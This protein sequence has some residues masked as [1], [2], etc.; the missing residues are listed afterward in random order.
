MA[1]EEILAGPLEVH[2][3]PRGESF[4]EP[5]ASPNGE[6][7]LLGASGDE[8]YTDDGVAVNLPQSIEEFIG[9]GS[10]MAIK[11]WR[12]EEAVEIVVTV[13]DMSLEVLGHALND[14]SETEDDGTREVSLYRGIDVTEYALLARGKS[15]YEDDGDGQFQI[16]ACYHSGEPEISNVKGEAASVE[17]TFRSLKP[18]E[19]EM[20][21]FKLIYTDSEATAP[22]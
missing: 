11:A 5:S 12:T 13:A 21:D 7:Q 15:P 2:L 16:P 19:D 6:W 8:N 17:F 22:A 9:A 18:S 3:A 14:N 1:R 4:P 10:T 20:A